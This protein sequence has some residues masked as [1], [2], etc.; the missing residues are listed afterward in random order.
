MVLGLKTPIIDL[1]G[2]KTYSEKVTDCDKNIA[3]TMST[4]LS[5]VDF[6]DF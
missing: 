1:G 4:T 5:L 3:P 6:G 2:L